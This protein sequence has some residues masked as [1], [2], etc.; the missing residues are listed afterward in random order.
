MRRYALRDDQFARIEGLL[1]GRPG[2]VGRNSELGNRLF[3]EAVIW[4]FRSGVNRLQSLTPP[5]SDKS[6]SYRADRHSAPTPNDKQN[7]TLAQRETASASSRSLG[8]RYIL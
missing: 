2:S 8:D 1:P 3:V 7:P 6:K 4:K 5:F